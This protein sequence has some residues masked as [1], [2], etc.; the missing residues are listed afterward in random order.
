MDKG[1][2]KLT[3][4][5]IDIPIALFWAAQYLILTGLAIQ[6]YIL[7]VLG[8]VSLALVLVQSTRIESVSQSDPCL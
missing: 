1:Q 3:N 2:N 6:T 4:T 5:E 8:M 7:F